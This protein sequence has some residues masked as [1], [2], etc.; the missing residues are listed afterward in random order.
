VIEGSFQTAV[1]TDSHLS[2]VFS[3]IFLR[4]QA[5]LAIGGLPHLTQ[6]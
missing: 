2:F 1:G 6:R 4:E 5:S 3:I